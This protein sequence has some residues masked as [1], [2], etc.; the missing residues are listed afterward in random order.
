MNT[1]VGAFHKVLKAAIP[2]DFCWKAIQKK[3]VKLTRKLLSWSPS[4]VL[5][6]GLCYAT[7]VF[8]TNFLKIFRTAFLQKQ[9]WAAASIVLTYTKHPTFFIKYVQRCWRKLYVKKT[10]N[11]QE[12][13]LIICMQLFGGNT[14]SYFILDF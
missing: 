12:Y 11:L 4:L 6:V 5:Q 1:N 7:A 10:F 2:E 13:G 3:F 9:L 8:M 14:K